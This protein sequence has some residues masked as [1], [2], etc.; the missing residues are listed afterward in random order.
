MP[1]IVASA[2]NMPTP[3]EAIALCE[4]VLCKHRLQKVLQ[5]SMD[6]QMRLLAGADQCLFVL[7]LP[8]T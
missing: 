4:P 7:M 1:I 2:V 8:G 3:Q 5:Q 6:P